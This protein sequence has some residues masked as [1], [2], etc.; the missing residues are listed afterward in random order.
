[1]NGGQVSLGLWVAAQVVT[2]LIGLGGLVISSMVFLRYDQWRKDDKT[3]ITIK[4]MDQQARDGVAALA[5]QFEARSEKVDQALQSVIAKVDAE[6]GAIDKRVF[7]VEGELRNSIQSLDS[8]VRRD[9]AAQGVQLAELTENVRHI[10]TQ[11]DLSKLSEAMGHLSR[12]SG[13]TGARLE[14]QDRLLTR[15][16]GMLQRLEEHHLK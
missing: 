14:G 10:P 4:Q 6:V 13:T 1:M 2:L 16:E 8:R 3:E 11:S 15:I 12:E 5:R 7:A 9:L